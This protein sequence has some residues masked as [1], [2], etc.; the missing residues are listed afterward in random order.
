[1]VKPAQMGTWHWYFG[2]DEC[3]DEMS[4]MWDSREEVIAQGREA[5]PDEPLYIVEGRH[6]LSDELNMALG[7]YDSAPFAETRNGEWIVAQEASNAGR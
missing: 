6:T 3:D 5:M 1:M 4:G 7:I 2:T